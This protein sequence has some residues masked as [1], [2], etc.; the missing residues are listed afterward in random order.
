MKLWFGCTINICA[1][2]GLVLF[3]CLIVVA[4]AVVVV[5]VAWNDSSWIALSQ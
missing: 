4:V 1:K 3:G 2:E 5:V